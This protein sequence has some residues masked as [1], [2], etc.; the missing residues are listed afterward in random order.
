MS[1]YCDR[2]V[3]KTAGKLLCA[4]LPA[5][6]C[7]GACSRG[8]QEIGRARDA[9]ARDMDA[10]SARM[11]QHPRD[12]GATDSGSASIADDGSDGG[13]SAEPSCA[14]ATYAAA[15]KPLDM[16]ILLDQSG[17]MTENDDRWTPVTQALKIFVASDGAAG[18]GVALQYFPLGPND[19]E[20]C[21]PATYATPDVAM[22]ALPGNAQAMADSIDAHY[23][24]KAECCNTP[25]HD[26][27]P[28]RPAMEGVTMYM[29]TWL[30]DH[31]D[32]AGVVLLA[33]D[34]E[35]SPVCDN[36]GIAEVSTVIA[37]AAAG[38]PAVPSYVIG[39]GHT[40]KLKQLATA[41]GTGVGPFI[42]DGTGV[43]TERELLD[44]L[45]QVRGEALPCDFPMPQGP[46]IDPLN[47]NVEHDTRGAPS[48]LVNVAAAAAC[49]SAGR[50]AW[51]YDVANPTQIVLCP[52]ACN[53]IASDPT[54]K[55]RIIVGC[56]TVMVR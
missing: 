16:F 22:R 26:G 40:D 3:R 7:A 38:T 37:D 30:T 32:H 44:A 2:F 25:Q 48:M 5:A 53:Q 9:G 41:G 47:V 24:T 10:A 43:N 52:E 46:G 34:G 11:P 39:I 13:L 36:N 42:V 6:I 23:F 15:L 21:K 1:T 55:I 27:T 12:S 28:T 35:P 45:A 49:S 29:R 56:A 54:S 18:L 31:P 8:T 14:K 33:T 4:V 20:K 51:Y 17:S 50:P 19:D